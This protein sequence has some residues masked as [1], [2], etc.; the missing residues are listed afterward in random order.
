[1]ASLLALVACESVVTHGTDPIPDPIAEVFPLPGTASQE[2]P[3]GSAVFTRPTLIIRDAQ[4]RGVRGVPVYFSPRA[5]SGTIAE[6]RT[7]TDSIGR[8]VSAL[9]TLSSALGL[10]Y[11]D[12]TVAAPGFTGPYTFTVTSVIGPLAQL[13]SAPDTLVL[14]GAAAATLTIT[15]RDRVGHPVAIDAAALVF[16]SSNDEVASVSASGAIATFGGGLARITAG[17]GALS[18]EVPVAVNAPPVADSVVTVPSSRDAYALAV[19]DDDRVLVGGRG[20]AGYDVRIPFPTA[21]PWA[22]SGVWELAHVRGEPTYYV[23]HNVAGGSEVREYSTDGSSEVTL[24]RTSGAVLA[25]AL[26]TLNDW[27]YVGKATSNYGGQLFR[28]HRHTMEADSVTFTDRIEGIVSYPANRSVFV[29]AGRVLYELDG[30]TLAVLR[31]QMFDAATRLA[32]VSADTR[33]LVLGP[34]TGALVLDRETLATVATLTASGSATDV[35]VH[36]AGDR[37]AISSS[38]GFYEGRVAEYALDSW[39]VVRNLSVDSPQRLAYNTSGY[40]LM[41]TRGSLHS[42]VFLR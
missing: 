23:A 6:A 12:A 3:A 5:G 29:T 13:T 26:D 41:V 24:L 11:L 27:V 14:P 22:A 42:M 37:V 9:W 19:F 2:L 16:T 21:V 32:L 4:G 18:V 17:L 7:E 40:V 35:A 8:A 1:M 20:S 31:S 34:S 30:E 33:L 39:A 38:L 10:Q 36:P 15:G 25:M 28:V